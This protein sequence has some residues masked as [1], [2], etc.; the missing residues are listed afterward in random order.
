MSG[1]LVIERFHEDNLQAFNQ[2]EALP[3]R[4]LG[5]AALTP[6]YRQQRTGGKLSYKGQVILLAVM[7]L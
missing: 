5:G 2:A 7:L 1:L 4:D 3:C 6:R